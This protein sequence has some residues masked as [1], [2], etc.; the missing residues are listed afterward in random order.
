MLTFAILL[1]LSQILAA[2]LIFTREARKKS[3]QEH[4]N[5]LLRLQLESLKRETEHTKES[6]QATKI[7][8]HDLRHHYMLLYTL[9]SQGEK[10]RALEH[11]L[12]QE[13]KLKSIKEKQDGK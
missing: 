1:T 12:G 5:D 6:I 13:G 11:I 4:I 7:M 3:Q 2:W 10:E 8:R 9:L